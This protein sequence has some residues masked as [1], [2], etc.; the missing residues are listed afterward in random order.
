MTRC[1]RVACRELRLTRRYYCWSLGEQAAANCQTGVSWSTFFAVDTCK[2]LVASGRTSK[3]TSVA[4]GRSRS[5]LLLHTGHVSLSIR[6]T[7]SLCGWTMRSFAMLVF[8]TNFSISSRPSVHGGTELLFTGNTF[9]GAL[10]QLV[11]LWGASLCWYQRFSGT[12]SG[13]LRLHTVGLSAYTVHR[14]NI[15]PVSC[16]VRR[17]VDSFVPRPGRVGHASRLSARRPSTLQ[18]HREF[19]RLESAV[20]GHFN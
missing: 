7:T 18:P 13:V 14:E 6:S 8:S 16:S 11:C 5:I 10:L 1:D 15:G 3:S 2:I 19:R 20:Q 12:Y 9:P 17:A 4:V